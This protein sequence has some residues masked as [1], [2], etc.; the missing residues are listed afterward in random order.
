MHDIGN[1]T[2]NDETTV[3]TMRMSKIHEH[4]WSVGSFLKI[5]AQNRQ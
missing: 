2:N 1:A 4:H 3:Q 5:T